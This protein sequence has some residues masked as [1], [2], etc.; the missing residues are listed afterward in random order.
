MSMLVGVEAVTSRSVGASETR[1]S[2]NIVIEMKRLIVSKVAMRLG[3]T[4][5]GNSPVAWV[6]VRGWLST[7]LATAYT[8]IRYS[9]SGARPVRVK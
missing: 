5:E 9:V 7:P 6:P 8:W 3:L 1:N 4:G 2:D